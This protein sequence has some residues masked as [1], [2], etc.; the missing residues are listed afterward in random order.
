MNLK[1][2]QTFCKIVLAEYTEQLQQN[3][4]SHMKNTEEEY[5]QWDSFMDVAIES[6]F[7]HSGESLKCTS[8]DEGEF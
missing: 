4:C 1:E 5:W 3:C 8:T 6:I 7:I 2:I